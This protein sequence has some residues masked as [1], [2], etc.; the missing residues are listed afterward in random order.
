MV[1]VQSY[2]IKFI[3]RYYSQFMI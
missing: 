3:A 2:Q 1:S